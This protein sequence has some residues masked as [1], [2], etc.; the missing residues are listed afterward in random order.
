VNLIPPILEFD[1]DREAVIE[2]AK[3]V[4]RRDLPERCVISFFGEVTEHVG[5]QLNLQPL[6]PFKSEM[7]TLPIWQATHRG[8]AFVVMQCAIG[9]PAAAAVL[10]EAIA[11][12]AAAV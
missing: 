3:A 11:R 6:V 1:P 5:E 9:A 2:P 8:I 4:E 7:G 10:E 12:A